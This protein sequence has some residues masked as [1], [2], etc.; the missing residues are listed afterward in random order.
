MYPPRGG[1]GWACIPQLPTRVV[2]P[3][4]QRGDVHV[5]P[6][7]TQDDDDEPQL[8]PLQLDVVKHLATLSPVRS[9]LACVF[10]QS[11]FTRRADDPGLADSGAAMDADRSYFDFALEQSEK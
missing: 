9:I 8:Y 3:G 11:C 2:K 10:G 5:V 6:T 1:K 4:S 7:T